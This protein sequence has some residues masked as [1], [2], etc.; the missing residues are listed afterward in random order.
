MVNRLMSITCHF[1]NHFM[2]LGIFLLVPT[3]AGCDISNFPSQR[4][5]PQPLLKQSTLFIGPNKIPCLVEVAAQ[6]YEIQL[7][8]MGRESLEKGT[9]MLFVFTKPIH[10]AF[11][12]KNTTL[13]LSIAYID[14]N[15]VIQEIHDMT[16]LD[17][18]LILSQKDNILY[19]LEVPR[20]WFQENH[21]EVGDLVQF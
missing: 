9:G 21:I 7:G 6:S 4:D 8:L 12:M 3:I 18:T 15:L 13:E 17:Q 14:A 10:A 2:L 20:G 1:M 19:A 5:Y 16:P 11:W